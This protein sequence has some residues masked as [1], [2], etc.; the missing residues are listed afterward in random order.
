MHIVI[1]KGPAIPAGERADVGDA[2]IDRRIFRLEYGR[3]PVSASADALRLTRRAPMA[4]T[5]A[6]R[7]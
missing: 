7:P 3:T 5:A 1:F 6:A 4:L 2:S